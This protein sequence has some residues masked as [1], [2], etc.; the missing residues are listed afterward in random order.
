MA[1]AGQ[2]SSYAGLPVR[3]SA[4]NRPDKVRKSDAEWKK[5]LSAQAYDVLRHEGTERAFTGSLLN[6]H[7][8]G[9]WS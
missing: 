5:L 7:D 3:T 6:V 8:D 9:T 2:S 4:P 1:T